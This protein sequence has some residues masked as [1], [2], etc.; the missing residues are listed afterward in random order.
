MHT[1]IINFVSLCL[2][3]QCKFFL[4]YYVLKTEHSIAVTT[5]RESSKIRSTAKMYINYSMHLVK[6]NTLNS[7][8]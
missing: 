1:D 5:Q 4:Q 6:N 7:M 3:S 2:F 8:L